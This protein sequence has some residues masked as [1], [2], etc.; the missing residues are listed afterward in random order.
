MTTPTDAE[1]LAVLDHHPKLH[2]LGY[3]PA[4][5]L[6][7]NLPTERAAIH[8]PH[9]LNQARQAADWI[10]ERMQPCSPRG[11]RLLT[12]YGA[13][14]F[15]QAETGIYVLNGPFILAAFAAGISLDT[16]RYNPTLHAV[17]RPLPEE[18]HP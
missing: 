6:R 12:S 16:T 18:R 8:A 7:I 4:R 5:G 9:A 2:L 3:G 17:P 13:K 1:F 10:T 11:K 14:H 15:M